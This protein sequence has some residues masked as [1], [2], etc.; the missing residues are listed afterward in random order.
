VDNDR[1]PELA[2]RLGGQATLVTS[3]AFC[4][5]RTLPHGGLWFRATPAIGEF[6]DERMRAVFEALAPV[7]LTGKSKFVGGHKHHRPRLVEGV[8]AAEYRR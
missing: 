5:V 6:A 3:G 2:S 1:S 7:L 4:D 8:D